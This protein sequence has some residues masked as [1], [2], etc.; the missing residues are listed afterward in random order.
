[1]YTIRDTV[2]LAKTLLNDVLE[3]DSKEFQTKCKD[4]GE[5]KETITDNMAATYYEL[6][7]QFQGMQ[8]DALMITVM[9]RL[10][11]ES[12]VDFYKDVVKH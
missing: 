9:S 1:M 8:F 11:L 4:I 5:M 6:K 12:H 3:D 2:V 7:S 10:A